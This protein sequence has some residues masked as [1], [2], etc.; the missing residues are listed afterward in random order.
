MRKLD[1][2]VVAAIF[3]TSLVVAPAVDSCT[4]FLVAGDGGVLFG[5]NEDFWN[6]ATGMW[7]VPA[8][9]ESLGAVFFG[10]DNLSPQGGMNEAGLTVNLGGDAAQWPFSSA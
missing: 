10:F 5:N 3:S 7:F 9:G 6:P 4:A 8:E 2:L 1:S